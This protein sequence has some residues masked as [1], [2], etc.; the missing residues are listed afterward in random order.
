MDWLGAM[1]DS[2]RTEISTAVLTSAGFTQ[3]ALG[4]SENSPPPVRL[5]REIVPAAGR[6]L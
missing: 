3:A 5:T 2:G 6:H 4:K 1:S